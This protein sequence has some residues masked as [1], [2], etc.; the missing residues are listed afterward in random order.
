MVN[1]TFFSKIRRG[2]AFFLSLALAGPTLAKGL[3]QN[4]ASFEIDWGSQKIRFLGEI[5]PEEQNIGPHFPGQKALG[6]GIVAIKAALME[7]YSKEYQ[8]LVT[9][10]RLTSQAEK[11]AARVEAGTYVTKTEYFAD[12]RVVTYLETNLTTALGFGDFLPAPKQAELA[13]SSHSGI[14]FRANQTLT[15]V[16]HYQIHGPDEAESLSFSQ[17]KPEAFAQGLMGRFFVDMTAS[18]KRRFIGSKALEVPIKE[19]RPGHFAVTDALAW[20]ALTANQS[21][22]GQSK[23]AFDISAKKEGPSRL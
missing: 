7:L 4:H 22:F 23:I 14:L 10:E 20:Q 8:D 5:G 3:V 15:P 12:G 2:C 18:E 16:S 6:F 19:L 11:A 1:N 21:L 13:K 17:I 9:S